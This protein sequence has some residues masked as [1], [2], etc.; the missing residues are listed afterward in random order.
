MRIFGI[1][2]AL[3]SVLLFPAGQ[4]LA[5]LPSGLI[6]KLKDAAVDECI[7]VTYS[8]DAKVDD[9]MIQDKGT[10]VAQGT[11]W[12]LKGETYEIYTSEKGTWVLHIQAKEAMVE[13]EW[14][15]DDLEKFYEN[16]LSNA[17]NEINL[18]DVLWTVSEKKPASFFVPKL[19]SDWIVTDL[20]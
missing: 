18:D 11:M 10:I 19:G 6:Q 15:Y 7:T 8:L 1:I 9:A 16:L 12:C 3:L 14:T 13:P 17:D 2:S 5:Q 4:A 20:R